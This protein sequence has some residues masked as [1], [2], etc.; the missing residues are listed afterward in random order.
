LMERAGE[1]VAR[2]VFARWWR[3]PVAVLCGPGNNGGD[4][5]VTA[6]LLQAEGWPV[7]L[8]LLGRREALGGDAARAA[9]RWPGDVG[10]LAIDVINDAALL[11]D[12]LFGAGLTRPL[13]G[14]ARAVVEAI[15]VRGLPCVAVDLPSGVHGDTGAVLGAAPQAVLT[16]T[17]FRPKPG[18]L[19]LPGRRLAGEVAVADI[20]IAEGVLD[21]IAPRHF[22]NRPDLWLADLPWPAP[23]SHKFSRG[24]VLIVG[25]ERMTGAARLAARG[26]RRI[27]AGL[28]TITCPP[29]RFATYAADA[30]G[31]LVQPLSRDDTLASL[32]ADPRISTVLI[33]PGAGRS[34]ATREHVLTVLAARKPCVLDADALTVFEDDPQALFAAIRGPCLMTPHEGELRRLFPAAAAEPSKLARAG[35]AAAASGAVVLLKGADTVVAEPRGR[36]IINADAP[37]TLA[38]A[39]A[40]DV[41]AGMAAGLMAQGMA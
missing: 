38:T 13:E 33:G 25:G 14:A 34:A 10:P 30:A 18:H 35:A 36:F 16:V 5:F 12:A 11:V 28:V 17:F 32:V 37:P 3:R 39:G 9:A 4:G 21:A 23:E 2:A 20:G 27:G 1:A 15:N 40:G 22:Q 29:E 19:L 26:A 41:L 31:L 24:H 6:R 7:R 8:A